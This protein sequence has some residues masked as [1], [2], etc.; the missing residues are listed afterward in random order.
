M[1]EY[2]KIFEKVRDEFTSSDKFFNRINDNEITVEE[3][4]EEITRFVE[5]MLDHVGDIVVVYVSMPLFTMDGGC[6]EFDVAII[7]KKCGEL[8][9]TDEHF[10]TDY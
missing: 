7:C 8:D 9:I 2:E 5:G 3:A 10:E 6:L 1:Y 4:R